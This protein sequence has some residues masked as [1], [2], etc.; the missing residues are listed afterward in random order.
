MPAGK[1]DELAGAFHDGS[2]LWAAGN[3]DSPSAPKLKQAL[4]PQGAKRTQ[5]RVRIYAEHGGQVTCW[6][7]A[8]SSLGLALGDCAADVRGDLFVEVGRIVAVDLDSKHGA[9]NNSS[10]VSVQAPPRPSPQDEL[11]ALIEEARRR[12]RRRRL[13]YVAVVAGLLTVAGGLY[14]GFGGGGGDGGTT[15]Q[16]GQSPGSGA[17]PSAARSPSAAKVVYQHPCPG[18]G[19]EALPL[20]QHARAAARSITDQRVG[21]SPQIDVVIRSA[22]AP[23]V[24][25]LCGARIARRTL[26][27]LT[28]D[29]RFDQGPN[30][31]ASLA[32][33]R[34]AVSRFGDG[35]HAWYSEH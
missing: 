31:S 25:H 26:W 6:R 2:P 32:Q 17:G 12:A 19:V 21:T 10:I 9:S 8:P 4:V 27:V 3:A 16:G 15:L 30:R 22:A 14:A 29:H 34:F 23:G 5:D 35:Y 18:R 20:T 7:Q 24:R 33:H 28:Y 13:A 11:D 1:Q